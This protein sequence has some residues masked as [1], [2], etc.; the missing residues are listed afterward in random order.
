MTDN[1]KQIRSRLEAEDKRLRDELAQLETE[2]QP[3][4][5]RREGSPFG[6]RE[7]EATESSELE[8]RLAL[9]K[10][11]SGAMAEIEHALHK[12]DVGTYGLCDSCGK[13]ISPDRLEA[14]PQA[15]LCVDCKSK[16][17]KGKVSTG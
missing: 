4:E 6:K 7:E 8:K 15:S 2:G 14:L 5:T 11:I 1:L 9:E 10:R 3:S 13:P 17:V 12:L 16:S